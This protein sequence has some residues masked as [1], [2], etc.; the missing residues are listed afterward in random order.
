LEDEHAAYLISEGIHV[1][2]IKDFL[3]VFIVN[4]LSALF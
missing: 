2:D 1:S 3:I 4:C